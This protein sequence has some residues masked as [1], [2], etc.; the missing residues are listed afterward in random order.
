MWPEGA[1]PAHPSGLDPDKLYAPSGATGEARF[2]A[3][4]FCVNVD[5]NERYTLSVPGSTA[6][7]IACA[8]TGVEN[9]LIA[10]DWTW[11]PVLNAGCVEATVSSGMEASRV[12]TGQPEIA[13]ADRRRPSASPAAHDER[14][15]H[16]PELGPPP[17]E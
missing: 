15:E 1:S 13:G 11:N 16:D 14:D 6:A 3:Q 4:F 9:L 10:G 8:E 5:P 7:R 17:S 2:D 12:L